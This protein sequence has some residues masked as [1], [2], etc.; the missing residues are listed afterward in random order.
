M[1]MTF[2]PAKVLG[3]LWQNIL[4]KRREARERKRIEHADKIRHALTVLK[5]CE[6]GTS[7]TARAGLRGR[8]GIQGRRRPFAVTWREPVLLTADRF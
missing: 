2:E 4:E 8:S 1:H 5:S 6:A 7:R 3:E